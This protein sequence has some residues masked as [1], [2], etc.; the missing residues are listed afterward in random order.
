MV[1]IA[2]QIVVLIFLSRNI[3]QLAE[4]RGVKPWL[5]IF[6]VFIAWTLVVLLVDILVPLIFNFSVGLFSIAAGYL[7]YILVYNI[8]YKKPAIHD[9]ELE[10]LASHLDRK[11]E[12]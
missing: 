12:G 7:G 5:W 4:F 11:D 10:E 6:Y 3:Y 8:L 9:E 2:V 1:A